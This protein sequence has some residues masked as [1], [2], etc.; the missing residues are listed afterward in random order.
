MVYLHLRLP[1]WMVY[2]QIVK[3]TIFVVPDVIATQTPSLINRSCTV[4]LA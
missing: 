2:K 3:R 4:E 1:S